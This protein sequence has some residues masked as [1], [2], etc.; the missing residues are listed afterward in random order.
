M[1]RSEP[2]GTIRCQWG[3]GPVWWQGGLHFVDIEGKAIHRYDP[4]DGS[5]R[6]WRL[7]QRVGCIIPRS[8][9]GFVIGGD[10][11]LFFFNDETGETRPIADPETGKPDNR[12]NDGKAAP[13]GRITR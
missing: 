6:T 2:V 7:D 3:E 11:G 12:F 4:A 9:G 13:D 8:T 5:E 1:I 10:H